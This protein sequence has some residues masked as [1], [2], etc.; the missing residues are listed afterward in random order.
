MHKPRL[1]AI[2]EGFFNEAL[3]HRFPALEGKSVVYQAYNCLG[4]F[5]Y[6]SD[7]G[8]YSYALSRPEE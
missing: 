4:F 6:L 5:W 2:H 8:R 1:T 3:G 7:K